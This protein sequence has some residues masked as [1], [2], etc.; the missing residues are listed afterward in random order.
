[1]FIHFCKPCSSTPLPS[2]SRGM[3][4]SPGTYESSPTGTR[5]FLSLIT[6][7][8]GANSEIA[9][10]RSRLM[11]FS[12]GNLVASFS[13]R[14]RIF[15]GKPNIGKCPAFASL[16]LK[17]VRVEDK[18]LWEWWKPYVW[19]AHNGFDHGYFPWRRTAQAKMVYPSFRPYRQV[20]DN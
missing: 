12:G 17:G 8:P 10:S 19:T 3:N 11:A 4:P 15:V 2:D 20:V 14:K 6:S 9:I 5:T 13:Y 18:D 16:S 1:M 7:L